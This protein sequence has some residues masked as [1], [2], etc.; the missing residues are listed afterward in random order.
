MR[1]GRRYMMTFG[2]LMLV[3][4]CAG[5][6]IPVAV[7]RAHDAEIQFLEAEK[8]EVAGN[9]AARRAV[10]QASIDDLW[11]AAEADIGAYEPTP[12][13]SAAAYAIETIKG[14]RAAVNVLAE[15]MLALKEIELAALDNLTLRQH[16]LEKASGV[17]EKSQ[18]WPEDALEWAQELRQMLK[19]D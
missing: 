18:Q 13:K 17:V 3:L 8:V 11:M 14:V 15:K 1:Y 10:I 16:M 19:E 6:S 7:I 5:C 4:A 9:Y 12:E 2:L